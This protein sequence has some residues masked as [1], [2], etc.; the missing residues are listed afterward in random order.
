MRADR[1]ISLMMLLQ[2]KGKMTA[3]ALAGELEVSERTIY[4]DIDAL[5]TAGVPI[6]AEGG[7][8]GGYALLDS[9]R[10]TLTGLKQEELGILFM[11]TI[12]GP[13]SDLAISQQL[14][15]TVLKVMSALPG[16]Y[17]EQAAHIYQRLH[18][19]A[20]GWFQPEEPVP[21][22]QPVQEAVWQDRQINI[23][24]LLA[25]GTVSQRLILPYGLVAKA[26]VW[27]LVA[28]TDKGRR[29]FRVSRIKGVESTA[30]N[31]VR[32]P[33]FDLSAFWT[34]WAAEYEAGLP[35]YPV[36]L[37]IGPNLVPMLPSILGRG[38]RPLLEQAVPDASGWRTIEYTFERVE[39]AQACIMGMG[40]D[41]EVLAPASL[42]QRI[43]QSAKEMVAYYSR[44]GSITTR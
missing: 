14:K 36:T 27:Y 38:I 22:L 31:F 30:V 24:Y 43:I 1:L 17:Q 11:L 41:A 12:P 28:D 2:V 32:P 18:L 9:Y 44:S 7:P 42:R 20:G 15:S 33:D 40:V 37:R 26:G 21:Y 23:S 19:D 6:Y 25:D 34:R 16:R 29:V 10:T 13:I 3:K 4:R 8:G 35:K 39:Q 5:S